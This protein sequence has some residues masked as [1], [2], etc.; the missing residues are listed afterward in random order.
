[1]S[2]SLDPLKFLVGTEYQLDGEVT[3]AALMERIEKARKAG[4]TN[5]SRILAITL[6]HFD[7]SQH[8]CDTEP[9]RQHQ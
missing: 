3:E 9:Q 7:I 2:T 4:H 1:M 5:V 8:D 6:L